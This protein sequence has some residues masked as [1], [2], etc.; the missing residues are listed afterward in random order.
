MALIVDN[1]D[2]ILFDMDGV[3]TSE[4]NYWNVAALSVFEMLYSDR[5]YG[6]APFDVEGCLL[7]L[8]D[9]RRTVF[10]GDDAIRYL[11]NVGVNSNWDLVYVVLGAALILDERDD[12]ARVY[13][14]LKEQ[15]MDAFALYEHVGAQL[16]E[17][18]GCEPA[19]TARLGPFWTKCTYCFQEW[20][21]GN[22]LF[23]RVWNTQSVQPGKRGLMYDEQPLVDKEQLIALLRMLHQK[24]KRVG[25]GTGRPKVEVDGVMDGWDVRQYFTPDAMIT[26]TDVMDA[27]ARL[28]PKDPAVALTKPHPYMFL[29]G[30]FG[31]RV[32]DA[33]LA[34][35]R[36]DP[37]PCRRT[38]VV[39]DAG[40]DLY[41]AQAAGC[42]FC[43]V[44][45]G[46]H[47]DAAR[48]FFEREHATYILP[49]VLAL[50]EQ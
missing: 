8:T 49:S 10:C 41:A 46:I 47:G 23:E 36:F 39:G 11:K 9:I 48:P 24:G 31:A 5:Y 37:A 26:Y 27:E 17:T 42:D 3:I 40:A 6:D 50:L 33:D 34:A 38:L 29:K 28:R 30:V 13:A 21:L 22:A 1:Y 12:F 14:Y 43:A 45:T 15:D 35:G 25:I 16:A 32:S 4:E 2:T 19:E 7:N 18:L 20:F 44:L